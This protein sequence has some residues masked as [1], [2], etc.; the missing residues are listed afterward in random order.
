MR[1]RRVR[2]TDGRVSVAAHWEGRWWPLA[3]FADRLGEAAFDLVRLL[4]GGA[5]LEAR[6]VEAIG[7][8]EEPV[9]FE[10]VPLLPFD[11]VSFRDFMLFEAHVVGATKGWLR[12]FRPPAYRMVL[13]Y[14][15]LT[16]RPHPRVRPKPLW[17]RRPIYYMGNPLAFVTE[18]EAVFWPGYT[19]ALDFELEVGWVIVRPLGRNPGPEEAAAAI[20]GFFVLNDFSARDVQ[21][22]EMQS[23]FG[24]VKAKNFATGI[25]LEVVSAGEVLPRWQALAGEV[26]VNGERVCQGRATGPRF[27]LPEV[28]AYAALGE[29]LVPGEV[30]ASGTLPGCSGLEAGRLLAPGDVVEARIEGVGVL[31]NRVGSP[32]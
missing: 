27:D 5:E 29:G 8:A 19:R 26:W 4:A 7:R 18:G 30:M 28:V 11:P 16:G 21:A 15:R 13:L 23:G 12:R 25:G 3:P 31:T 6:V 20:G 9:P 22:A 24:P 2:L 17:Y 1:F 14:E 10:N 32:S